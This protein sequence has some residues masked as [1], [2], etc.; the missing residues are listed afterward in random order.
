MGQLVGL[1]GWLVGRRLGLESGRCPGLE[2]GGREVP[3]WA[4][5][6]RRLSQ[7]TRDRLE[8]TLSER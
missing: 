7:P 6:R 4:V 1:E 5:S 8:L 2:S 3:G